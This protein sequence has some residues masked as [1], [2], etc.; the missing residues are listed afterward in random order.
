MSH[1]VCECGRPIYVRKGRR[2]HIADKMHD[3]CRRCYQQHRDS[4]R[5]HPLTDKLHGLLFEAQEVA[6]E[7]VR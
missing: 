3:K 7:V 6:E 1:R 5:E 4:V 2:R